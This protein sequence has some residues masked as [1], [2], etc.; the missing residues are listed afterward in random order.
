MIVPVEYMYMYVTMH[1][2]VANKADV[3]GM[4]WAFDCPPHVRGGQ[5][6]R[7]SA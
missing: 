7:P 1:V 6:E 4:V 5:S 3:I 2:T